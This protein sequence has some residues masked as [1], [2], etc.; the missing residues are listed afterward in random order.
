MTKYTLLQLHGLRS[1]LIEYLNYLKIIP[2]PQ[3]NLLVRLTLYRNI[4]HIVSLTSNFSEF[5]LSWLS[6]Y[7]ILYTDI[8]LYIDTS[9]HCQPDT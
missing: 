9:A 3:I 1:Y 2:N 5:E 6:P 8:F 4:L 7:R